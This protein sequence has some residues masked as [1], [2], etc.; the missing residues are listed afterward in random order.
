MSSSHRAVNSVAF[1][2]EVVVDVALRICARSRKTLEPT[3]HDAEEE[4]KVGGRKIIMQKLAMGERLKGQSAQ[5]VL[6][7]GGQ[8]VRC[9]SRW[10]KLAA[11]PKMM[12]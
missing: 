9:K 5:S 6:G 7:E 3:G 12:A 8:F 1:V 11:S 4:E 10:L 2:F